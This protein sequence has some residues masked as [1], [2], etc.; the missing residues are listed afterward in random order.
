MNDDERYEAENELLENG[1]M[2]DE[3]T[4]T[5]NGCRY[6]LNKDESEISRRNWDTYIYDVADIKAGMNCDEMREFPDTMIELSYTMISERDAL[7]DYVWSGNECLQ[8]ASTQRAGL[9][10]TE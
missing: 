10:F 2:P 1:I 7:E 5:D 9:K 4:F 8:Y 3:L 6:K